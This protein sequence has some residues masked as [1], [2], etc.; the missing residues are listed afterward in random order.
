MFRR[1]KVIHL[2]DLPV[3]KRGQKTFQGR[4]ILSQTPHTITLKKPRIDPR[5][6]RLY[7]VI[8]VRRK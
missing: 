7:D 5:T 1:K 2:K 3:V 6:G 8:A 4:K